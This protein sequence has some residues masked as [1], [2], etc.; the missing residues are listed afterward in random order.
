MKPD[1]DYLKKM[2]EAFRE[3]PKP[4]MD[5]RE[6]AKAGLNYEDDIFIFHLG[7][8]GDQG[9]VVAADNGGHS[10]RDLGIQRGAG[11]CIQWSVVPLRLTAAGQEF[12][13]ALSHNKIVEML[14]TKFIGASLSALSAAAITMLRQGLANHVHF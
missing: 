5:I 14:K 9:F 2:L 8:L 10:N 13:E 4:T 11:D 6:L 7:L 3:S 12:A 1:V